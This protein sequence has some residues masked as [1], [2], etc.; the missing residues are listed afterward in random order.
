MFFSFQ[1]EFPKLEDALKTII[2]WKTS[3]ERRKLLTYKAY[4]NGENTFINTFS[5]LIWSDDE[6]R[7][8]ENVYA[9][10]YKTAYGF[11]GNMVSQKN[12]AL[13][14]EI[15][16]VDKMEMADRKK[17]GFALKKAG[18][19]AS[20]YGYAVIYE[21]FNGDYKVFETPDC[22]IF[23]DDFTGEI[24]RVIRFWERE[25][26]NVNY[27]YFEIYDEDG[28]T[29]YQQAEKEKEPTVFIPKQYYKVITFSSSINTERQSVQLKRLPIV[30]YRNNEECIA[31]LTL[32]VKQKIDLID[33][34]QSGFAN[35]IEEFSDVWMSINVP[36]ATPEQVQQI[37]EQARRAKAILFAG[38]DE[39]N[40]ADFKTLDIPYEARKTAIEMI[41]QELV[42]DTGI[43]DFKQ[44]TG[45]ATAT[46]INARTYKLQQRVSDFEWF[47]DECAT[48][49]IE[50]WQDYNNVEFDID[51]TF[52]K[53][54][55]KNNTEIVNIANSIYGKVSTKTYLNQL[56]LAGVIDDV[57][58]EI[59]EL[60]KE[61]ISKFDLGDLDFGESTQD[62]GQNAD[63]LE[64]TDQE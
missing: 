19:N 35:N 64:Q 44:I 10:N 47:S 45:S 14:G 61:S 42:E 22:L 18:D 37:K 39:K 55:I 36:S 6:K 57:D 33:I 60:E 17:L 3:A 20:T 63:E 23:T 25:V 11:Y 9:P 4:R 2:K 32:N 62:N 53:L 41:K 54:F 50:I 5:R 48:K 26:N 8:V 16:S 51:I 27:F 13:Y 24:K 46:E 58:E 40:S 56:Q 52:N 49:L 29:T 31:D 34:I 21:M 30:I 59:M 1:R 12:N 43:I 15:P 28:I 38:T 7:M